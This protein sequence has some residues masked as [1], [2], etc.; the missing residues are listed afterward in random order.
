MLED[1]VVNPET[2]VRGLRDRKERLFGF[3]LAQLESPWRDLLEQVPV[4]LESTWRQ[5]EQYTG[6]F[7]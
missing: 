5:R 7:G 3:V 6:V 4:R 1:L 2:G